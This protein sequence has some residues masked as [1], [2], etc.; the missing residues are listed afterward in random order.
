MRGTH[1]EYTRWVGHLIRHHQ[2]HHRHTGFVV[3]LRTGPGSTLL[4]QATRR[5]LDCERGARRAGPFL[6][7]LLFPCSE[8]QLG[9]CFNNG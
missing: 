8:W 2:H 4:L 6:F 1:I 5:G 9:H 7:R 3:A